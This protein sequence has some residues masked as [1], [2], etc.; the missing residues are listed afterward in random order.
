MAFLFRVFSFRLPAVLVPGRALQR[1]ARHLFAHPKQAGFLFFRLPAVPV[2]GC[3]RR[4]APH[5]VLRRVAGQ[6]LLVLAR[7]VVHQEAPPPAASLQDDAVPAPA[8]AA[9]RETQAHPRP[10]AEE[11]RTS[12]AQVL[13]PAPAE[14]CLGHRRASGSRR[15]CA[16]AAGHARPLAV[17]D[18]KSVALDGLLLCLPRP[19]AVHLVWRP[20][21]RAQTATVTDVWADPQASCRACLW[22]AQSVKAKHPRGAPV[23]SRSHPVVAVPLASACRADPAQVI[24]PL[25]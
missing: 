4:W 3:V 21:D 13:F 17:K 18:E 10:L 8:A 25:E 20:A 5:L 12:G 7:R 1:Q 19:E 6:E 16:L 22:L 2:P 14:H 15:A 9:R 23:A 11:C 24:N